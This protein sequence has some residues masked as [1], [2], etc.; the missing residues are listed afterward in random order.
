M[1]LN[2]AVAFVNSYDEASRSDDPQ[3]MAS[4]YAEPYTSFTLGNVTQF[5]TRA[6]ALAQAGRAEEMQAEHLADCMLCGSCSYVCPSSIPLAQMFA[7][8]KAALR[9]QVVK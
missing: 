1:E 5:A 8:S 3:R 7:L 9:R 4:H 2:Q 6:E